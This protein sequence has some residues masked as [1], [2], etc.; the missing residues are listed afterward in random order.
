MTKSNIA[1]PFKKQNTINIM[2]NLYLLISTLNTY[3]DYS[4]MT[5]SHFQLCFSHNDFETVELLL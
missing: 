2:N 4:C 5:L 1:Y 3:K